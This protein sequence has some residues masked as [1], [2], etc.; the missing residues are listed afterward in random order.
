VLLA[1][2]NARY[3]TTAE[4]KAMTKYQDDNYGSNFF[5]TLSSVQDDVFM[6]S[7]RRQADQGT[8]RVS[9]LIKPTAPVPTRTG[10]PATV[11]RK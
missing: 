2:L 11:K 6:K 3:Y 10:A 5:P 9:L 7:F 4:V 8:S 1:L